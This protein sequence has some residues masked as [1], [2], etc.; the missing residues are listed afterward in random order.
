[1]GEITLVLGGA[2]SGKSRWVVEKAKEKFG[3]NVIFIATAQPSDEEMKERILQHR[4]EKP[5]S[6][7]T[8]EEPL[9]IWKVIENW[10]DF[11]GGVIVDCV[12]LWIAN[13]MEKGKNVEEEVEKFISAVQKFRGE[14]YAVSNE[15]G[16]GLVPPYPLGR[17]FRDILGWVNQRLA[18]QS[19]EVYLMFAGIPLKIK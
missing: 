9:S 7:R 15:V 18:S 12:T 6:W 14:L 10:E 2:R 16:M 4:K 11:Q 19:K 8:I 3:D 5:S 17:K 13:I 1:M